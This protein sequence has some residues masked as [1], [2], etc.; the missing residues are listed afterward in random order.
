MTVL[1]VTVSDP[2]AIAIVA[3][4]VAVAAS[5]PAWLNYARSRHT[6]QAIGQPNGGGSVV[7]MLEQIAPRIDRLD[8]RLD[9]IEGQGNSVQAQMLTH[10]EADDRRFRQATAAMDR[11]S[12]RLESI[13]SGER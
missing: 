10:E 4:C 1:A 13:E 9:H 2:D 11:I 7:E 6:R 8:R 5:L 12:D 3:L